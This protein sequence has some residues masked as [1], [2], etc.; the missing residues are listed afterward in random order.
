[1]GFTF[2]LFSPLVAGG[3]LVAACGGAAPEAPAAAPADPAPIHAMRASF[4]T[5]YNAGDAAAVA[6]LYEDDAI[7]MPDHRPLIE[8]RA[9]IQQWLQE[10]FAQFTPKLTLTSGDLEI[11]GDLAHEHGSYTLTLTPKAGGEAMSENGKYLVILKRQA[12][13]AWKLH[14][15]ITNSNEPPPMPGGK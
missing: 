3:L 1:M 12:D 14:H 11:T 8:G 2:R 10:T 4:Q 6:A 15:N 13:G 9:A 5:A 7:A